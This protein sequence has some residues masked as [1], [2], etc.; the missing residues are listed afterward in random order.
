MLSFVNFLFTY[1]YYLFI[2]CKYNCLKIK[3][4]LYLLPIGHNKM[5]P[6]IH[7]EDPKNQIEFRQRLLKGP[8]QP[9]LD[10]FP[11]TIFSG[12]KR[13]F[14]KSWYQ[15]FIWLEYSPK[16]DL[17]FCFPCRMF[18]GSTGLNIGQSELVYSKI[19]FKNWKASTSKLSVHEKSKNHL[20]SSTSLALFLNSKLIDEVIDDQ[21]KNI[22][23]VKELT[24]QKK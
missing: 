12:V 11:R 5:V 19:G 7:P 14:Q 17:A 2:T 9:V 24:R 20:N 18:S 15:Q 3:S 8:F 10:I 21:R 1:Y 23:N 16:Y 22:D 6:D 4:H 13:S